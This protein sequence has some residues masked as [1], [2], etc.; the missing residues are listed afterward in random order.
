M[1]TNN[2]NNGLKWDDYY[3]LENEEIDKQ[4]RGLFDLVNSL[5]IS[6]DEGKDTEKIKETLLFLVNYTLQH[7]NDEEALQKECNYPEYEN[8]KKLHDDFKAVV[9]NLVQ[10]FSQTGSSVDLSKDVKKIVIKW[11]VKHIMNE[12]KKIGRHMKEIKQQPVVKKICA[13]NFIEQEK[14]EL[15]A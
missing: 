6:C 4:H 14:E 5:I 11:L 2:E 10:R 8:H 1:I 7:F 15:S 3:S 9:V 12:D 13:L